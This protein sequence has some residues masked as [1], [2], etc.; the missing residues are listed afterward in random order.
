MEMRFQKSVGPFNKTMSGRIK[1][2]HTE[3]VNRSRVARQ[4]GRGG[5]DE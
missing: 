3:T 2:V 5:K 1:K 4:W